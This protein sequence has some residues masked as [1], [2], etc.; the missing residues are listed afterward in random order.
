MTVIPRIP[1]DSSDILTESEARDY[2]RLSPTSNTLA[3]WRCRNRYAL[4]FVR[5]GRSIR[6]RRADLDAFLAANTVQV[7]VES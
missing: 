3:V 1:S 7:V 6:Y 2:L 4:P 5:V